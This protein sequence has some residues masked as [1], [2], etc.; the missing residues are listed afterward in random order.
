MISRFSRTAIFVLL[1]ALPII[2]NLSFGS[3]TSGAFFFIAI[4][5]SVIP[6]LWLGHSFSS[7][8]FRLRL[9]MTQLAILGLIILGL[10]QLLPVGGVAIP[11]GIL[12]SEPSSALSVDPNATRLA[13]VRLFVFGVFYAAALTFL[14][15]RDRIR[16]AVVVLIAFGSLMAFFAVLQFLSSPETILGFTPAAAARPYG[17]YVNRHHF[18]SLLVMIFAVAFAQLLMGGAKKDRLVFYL[19]AILLLG[20]GVI[21]AGSRGAFLSLI[22]VLAFL[23]VG[24]LIVKRSKSGNR[25][26]GGRSLLRNAAVLGIS[27]IGFL[28]LLAF[29][30]IWAGGE[31]ELIRG[32]A[33]Q[34]EGE[35]F[36]TGRIHFWTVA[37]TIF[38]ANP[39]FGSGLESFGVAFTRFDTMN[40]L[41]R[42]EHAHNEYLQM[43]SDGGL[44]GLALVLFFI[45]F[46]FRGAQR[47]IR[48][49][50][51][52]FT[53]AAS[54]GALAGC[55]GVLV[56]SVV[57]FPLRTNANMFFFLLLAAIAIG[58]RNNGNPERQRR[59]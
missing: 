51:E 36:S 50:R 57:D 6:A 29:V 11:E 12:S 26:E 42:V 2:A 7:G 43:L 46:L 22:A 21:F 33:M 35:D 19:I 37:L 18:A 13:I 40:G 41:Y 3:V 28:L 56:H 4:A 25:S 20:T 52:K 8:E 17:T 14:N 30:A 38:V 1:L 45:F 23:G 49:S 24:V 53:A 58:N 10:I 5:V 34:T 9:D 47:S 27:T 15:H 31:Q 39:V 54:L 59:A 32:A 44:I 16:T 55:F 48:S